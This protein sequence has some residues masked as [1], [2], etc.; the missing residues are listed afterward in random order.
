MLFIGS[1]LNLLLPPALPVTPIDLVEIRPPDPFPTPTADPTDLCAR[2]LPPLHLPLLF[3]Q[4]QNVCCAT[5]NVPS[6]GG[7]ANILTCLVYCVRCFQ[8]LEN[9]PR[10]VI[11]VAGMLPYEITESK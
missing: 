2:P 11:P 5:R 4:F 7:L 8:I 6:A 3:S 9:S 1:T 10:C